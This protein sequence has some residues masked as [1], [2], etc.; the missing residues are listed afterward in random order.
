[1]RV[2]LRKMHQDVRE[3]QRLF[4]EQMRKDNDTKWGLSVLFV[5]HLSKH[6]RH[7]GKERIAK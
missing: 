1:M 2:V 5:I 4:R 3:T 6:P 7:E